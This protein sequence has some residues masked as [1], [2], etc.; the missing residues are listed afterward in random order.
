MTFFRFI[1]PIILFLVILLTSCRDSRK[2][3]EPVTGG[4]LTPHTETTD[5]GTETDNS[6]QITQEAILPLVN[7]GESYNILSL[8]DGNLDLEQSDEQV[9]IALPLDD[10]DE[11]LM[12]MIASTNPIRNQYDIVWR[13]ALSTRT[14]TG[15]TLRAD[16][17]TGNGRSDLVIAGF[18]ERGRHVTEVFAVPK[19]GELQ[20]FTRVFSLMVDG[21][22]DIITLDRSPGYWSGV[23]AGT[24]YR[25]VVQKTDPDSDNAM[26]IVET[27]WTWDSSIFS[28]RQGVTRKVEATTIQE[29]R[30][31]RVYAGDVKIYE[32]YLRGAW[33]REGGSDKD[34]LYFNPDSREIMFYDGSIQEIF[35]WGE[36]HRTTA[37][38]LYTRV[39]NVV[40]PS[41]YD[42]VSVSAENW[43]RLEL[44]RSAANW[45]GTYRRLGPALQE[46]LDSESRLEP[47]I[48]K[49]PLTGVWKSPMGTELVF[50]MPRI[51]WRDGEK[52][53]IG[54]A[55]LFSLND[56][57]ILQVRF[58]K[59]NGAFEETANWLVVY[60]E[61]RDSTRIIRS[62]SLSPAVLSADGVRE[63]GEVVRRFEQIEVLSSA[64]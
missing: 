7:P 53:R 32:N 12:L 17:L 63:A 37:K 46:I 52:T 4:I 8:L 58:M 22:I 45:N 10:P 47:L 30:I 57:L 25:I 6:Y 3:P 15:I 21:N 43:E 54:T 20:D 23:S 28:Y 2:L 13:Q 40:I 26:D 38:R 16:D 55:S 24:P 14:L 33:Y 42:T 18:D 62:L 59:K 19:N 48:S 61:D 36:S 56:T 41:M 29:E 49:L 60:D 9:I 50:D 1:T 27:D 5:R 31:A 35:S 64:E 34:M 44:W 11:P 39:N 51:E